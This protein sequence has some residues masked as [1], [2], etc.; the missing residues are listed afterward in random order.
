MIKEILKRWLLKDERQQLEDATKRVQDSINEFVKSEK[1]A[2]EKFLKSFNAADYVFKKLGGFDWQ[3]V[4]NKQIGIDKE[5][6]AFVNDDI[7]EAAKK[8]GIGEDEL[9]NGAVAITKDPAFNF[10][11]EFLQGNQIV[12]SFFTSRSAEETN[13]TRALVGGHAQ[14]RGEFERLAAIH[15]EKHK[16]PPEFD[17]HAAL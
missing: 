15:A 5:G 16:E 17:R 7:I 12:L 13:F 14:V 9:L 2:K 11:I 1:E 10:V 4:K 3:M 6:S 8:S